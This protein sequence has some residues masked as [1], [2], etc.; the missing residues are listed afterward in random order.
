M[1]K[2]KTRNKKNKLLQ[3]KY[4][5]LITIIILTV[6]AIAL[7]NSSSGKISVE[8]KNLL[9]E[10]VKYGKLD[11][12]VEG[13]GKLFSVKQQ[14]LTAPA[15]SI[16]KE[17]LLKP[18]AFVSA[19]SMIVR[20]ENPL[21][22][23]EVNKAT[24]NLTLE[25]ANLRKLELSN[26][27]EYL[28]EMANLDE[29]KSEYESAALRNQAIEKLFNDKAVS[30][31]DYNESRLKQEQLLRR[32]DFMKQRLEQLKLVHAESIEIQK[33][34]VNQQQIALNIANTNA[35]QLNVKAGFSG[36]LQRLSVEL[37]QSLEAGQEIA[38]LGS[39][40]ELLAEIHIP[41]NYAQQVSVGQTAIIDTRQDKIEGTVARID[42][43]VE[44]NSVKVEIALP[45]QLP[46]S[47]RPFLNV[48]GTII[49]SSLSDVNY[50][51][52]P[53]NI[54]EDSPNKLF[55][56]S[57]DSDEAQLHT[58]HFGKK[59]G[60]Y[61]EILSGAAANDR[62]IISDLSNISDTSTTLTIAQ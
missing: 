6:T 55:R 36:V 11:I 7:K 46:S 33:E 56:L 45:D 24:Q 61:I 59:A 17:I 40:K 51:K 16:V 44:D 29:I 49:I 34:Q 53:A 27:R 18:G 60:Q 62:F 15:K 23:E 26:R 37:G 12:T 39:D 57:I 48:D 41:Q 28:D 50:I 30:Q 47:T 20:L 25:Q 9:I 14:L 42:P 13:Y 10:P 19:E 54:K 21:L 32:V 3:P 22:L 1:D 58:L 35:D 31:L 4:I 2:I 8:R 52:Q 43:L 5:L 38:L